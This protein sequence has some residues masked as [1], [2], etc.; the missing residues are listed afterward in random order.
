MTPPALGL[1]L[2]Q[3]LVPSLTNIVCCLFPLCPLR[4]VTYAEYH[5]VV[6]P[7]SL[8]ASGCMVSALA[9]LGIKNTAVVEKKS[10]GLLELL[11]STLN[12]EKVRALQGYDE[13]RGRQDDSIDSGIVLSRLVFSVP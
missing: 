11:A 7:P 1:T 5:F 2:A 10:S 9:M 8:I 6:Y 13:I 3:V 4:V 12:V